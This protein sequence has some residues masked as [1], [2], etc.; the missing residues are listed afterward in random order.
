MEELYR[1]GGTENTVLEDT[2][3]F[4]CTGTQGKAVTPQESRPD[5]PAGL[6]GSPGEAG[7]GCGS[8]W[9]KDTGGKDTRE[10][11]ML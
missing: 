8:L 5:L 11:S 1:T 2:H 10:Y 7:I 4:M 9:D 6:G 3:G